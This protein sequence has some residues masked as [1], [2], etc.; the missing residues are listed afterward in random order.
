[1]RTLSEYSRHI[2]VDAGLSGSRADNRPEL[3]AALTAV[4]GFRGAI[5]V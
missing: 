2:E 1:M 4:A 3:Q 5:V